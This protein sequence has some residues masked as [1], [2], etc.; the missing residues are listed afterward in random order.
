MPTH[1][2]GCGVCRGVIEEDRERKRESRRGLEVEKWG[3][4]RRVWGGVYAARLH[5]EFCVSVPSDEQDSFSTTWARHTEKISVAV[6]FLGW[7]W[8]R[9]RYIQRGFSGYPLSLPYRPLP[10]KEI[11]PTAPAC[12][13]RLVDTGKGDGRVTAATQRS[14]RRKVGNLSVGNIIPIIDYF[15]P[16]TCFSANYY[17]GIVSLLTFTQDLS[18]SQNQTFHTF[19]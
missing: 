11:A 3:A 5:V 6:S 12:F 4:K 13:S 15:L 16:E 9:A 14:K 8:G 2:P 19:S 7:K 1:A 10:P 17:L 18:S